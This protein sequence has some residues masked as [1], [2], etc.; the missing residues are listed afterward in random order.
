[1]NFLAWIRFQFERVFFCKIV[2]NCES[3]YVQVLIHGRYYYY[4]F[5][6][7]E[8]SANV[9][10]LHSEKKSSEFSIPA[11]IWRE[12]VVIKSIA[13]L[14]TLM[15]P[16]SGPFQHMN[17]LALFLHHPTYAWRRLMQSYRRLLSILEL[18][19]HNVWR[20]VCAGSRSMCTCKSRRHLPDAKQ[21]AESR[22]QS[23]RSWSPI[24]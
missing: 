24:M 10:R 3:T 5:F 23:V 22:V 11:R 12:R 16:S 9:T 21:C 8:L 7:C 1:M 6:C 20:L 17:L 13:I 4:Y 2:V 14:C 15:S 19:A 18:I